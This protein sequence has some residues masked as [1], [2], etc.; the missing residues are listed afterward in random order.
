MRQKCDM[1]V[2]IKAV[3]AVQWLALQPHSTSV[4]WFK[5]ASQL[6]R[7]WTLSMGCM[8]FLPQSTD[9]HLMS[10]GDSKLRVGVSVHVGHAADQQPRDS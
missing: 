10:T 2:Y 7:V 4:Q 8:G 6:C 1:N 9:M 5:P 3:T